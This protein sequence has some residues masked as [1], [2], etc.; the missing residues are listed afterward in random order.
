VPLGINALFAYILP[1][2]WDQLMALIG[3][4]HLWFSVAWPF[5]DSGGIPGLLN[6]ALISIFMLMLTMGASRM[7]LRLKF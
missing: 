2:V 1:D 5:L 3:A 6:A 7:G 4:G